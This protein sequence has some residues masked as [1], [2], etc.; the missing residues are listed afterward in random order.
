MSCIG[1]ALILP[2]CTTT[3]VIF[4]TKR[5]LMYCG[6][7]AARAR[8]FS[9]LDLLIICLLRFVAIRTAA[10][11]QV[12]TRS[13]FTHSLFGHSLLCQLAPTVRLYN[14]FSTRSL[15]T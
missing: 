1:T 12:P 9:F 13:A 11:G 15:S 4:I 14:F 10:Q 7:D 2:K 6:N 3:T 5:S 8:Q